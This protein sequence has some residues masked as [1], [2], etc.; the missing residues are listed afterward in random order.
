M[1]NNRAAKDDAMLRE[2]VRRELDAEFSFLE[3]RPSLRPDILG[4]IKGEKVVKKKISVA[5]VFA[6]VAM[7]AAMTAL[8]AGLTFSNQVDFKRAAMDALKEKYGI[9]PEMMTIFHV[10]EM[11]PDENGAMT[12]TFTPIEWQY[13]GRVGE[14]AVTA[15]GGK[16]TASWSH[17][18]EEIGE[19]KESPVYG[20]EQIELLLT[21]YSGVMQYLFDEAGRVEPESWGEP[22]APGVTP[23]PPADGADYFATKE[24]RWEQ[25]KAAAEAEAKLSVEECRTL[26]VE[27]IRSLYGLTDAQIAKLRTYDD[28]DGMT[29]GVEDGHHVI[30][31]KYF[32]WQGDENS[33]HTT[34]D[35]QYWIDVNMDTGIIEDMLY[36]SGMAANG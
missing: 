27:A 1:K 34:M 10:R 24:E 13:A 22:G 16:V 3:S 19:G 21:D 15:L 17:D 18:G 29:F 2:I 7:L 20:T 11:G 26:A 5:L 28:W 14:Y 31:I 30:T 36:D 9:T 8:A 32:L 35:G 6:L 33:A 25:S 12:L 4:R 23:T